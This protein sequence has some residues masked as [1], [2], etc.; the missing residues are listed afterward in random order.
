MEAT[1]KEGVARADAFMAQASEYETDTNAWDTI[2]KILA[3]AFRDHPFATL[4]AAELQRTIAELTAMFDAGTEGCASSITI[5]RPQPA[6]TIT[7]RLIFQVTLPGPGRTCP[8]SA[9]RARTAAR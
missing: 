3:T 9:S 8:D 7:S 5:A 1:Q 2:L 4:R 6:T